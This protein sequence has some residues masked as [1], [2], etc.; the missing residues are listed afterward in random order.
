MTCPACHGEG[1]IH[2]DDGHR[3]A[4][5]YRCFRECGSPIDRTRDRHRVSAAEVAAVERLT[6]AESFARTGDV[7]ALLDAL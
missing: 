7:A 6:P 1:E 2:Q 5:W 3:P 4:G